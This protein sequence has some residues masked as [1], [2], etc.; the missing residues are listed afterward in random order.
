MEM[1]D[2]RLSK[3]TTDMFSE[4]MEE[5]REH[6]FK[7]VNFPLLLSGIIDARDESDP[8]G[9]GSPLE[10]YLFSLDKMP[11]EIYDSIDMLITD[12]KAKQGIEEAKK[13]EAKKENEDKDASNEASDATTPAGKETTSHV[14]PVRK[15]RSKEDLEKAQNPDAADENLPVFVTF[16]D[17]D[18]NEL[19]IP[20]DEDIVRVSQKLSEIIEKFSVTEIEPLHFTVALFMAD[21]KEFRNFFKEIYENYGDAKAFFKAERILKLGCIPFTLSAFLSIKNDEIDVTRPS[22]ER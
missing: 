17:C 14:I 19:K 1:K 3:T 13:E 7:S 15:N 20:A 9:S 18:G 2:I 12:L 21:V 10:N 8:N 11:E 5:M 6:G 22:E 16:T 4:I